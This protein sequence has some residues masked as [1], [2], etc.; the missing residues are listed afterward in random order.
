MGMQVVVLTALVV[1]LAIGCGGEEPIETPATRADACVAVGGCE[2]PVHVETGPRQSIFRVLVVRDPSGAV[3][4]EEVQEVEVS[5]RVGAPE[6]PLAGTHGLAALDAAGAPVEFQYLRFAD[7]L[8]I[9]PL[10][11]HEATVEEDLTGGEVST[12][13]YVTLGSTVVELAIVDSTGTIVDRRPAPAPG[14]ALARDDGVGASR[15]AV[16]RPSSASACS[17]VVLLEGGV[18]EIWYPAALRSRLRLTPLSPTQYAVVRSALGRMTPLHCAGISRMAFASFPD[19]GVAGVVTAHAGDLV[20]LNTDVEFG[21]PGEG[22]GFDEFSLQGAGQQ[23]RLMHVIFHEGGHAAEFL[24]D[25]VTDFESFPGE[26]E[27]RQGNLAEQTIDRVRLRG[28]FAPA[29]RAVHGSFF[30]QGWTGS[31]LTPPFSALQR[32]E[33]RSLTPEGLAEYGVI[34]QYATKQHHEDIADTVAYPLSAP[35]MRAAGLPDGPSPQV[36]DYGCIAMRA[37]A[38]RSVPQSLAA[39]FTKLAFVRDLGL[40]TDEDFESCAG[41]MIGIPSEVE[42]ITVLADGEVQRVFASGPEAVIGTLDGRYVFEFTVGGTAEFSGMDYGAT[43]KLIIDLAPTGTGSGPTPLEHVSWPR[44]LYSL[45]IGQPHRFELRMP[46][47]PAGNFNVTDGFVLITEASNDRIVGSV[48]ARE[49]FRPNAPIPVP[50]VFDPP[51][52]FRFTITN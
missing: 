32:M 35:I 37:H 19:T 25:S 2:T 43:L 5:A 13:G 31:Y 36:N 22:L 42:G 51:L 47:A 21:D 3:R 23:A 4:I 33:I 44:G 52:N 26:W 6:G 46:D 49:A 12:V 27:P 7:T 24:L 17:H 8:F 40:I 18:D 34:S 48:F 29:W 45:A 41:T 30:E 1:S 10:E 39:V 50:Q 11:F 38:E 28:G 16:V 15:E 20:I 9:E 14:D